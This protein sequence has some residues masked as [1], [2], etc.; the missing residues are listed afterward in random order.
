MTTQL[1]FCLS[2]IAAA[3]ILLASRAALAQDAP[4]T[5]AAPV[6]SNPLAGVF[7]LL[8]SN[9]LPSLAGLIQPEKMGVLTD[10]PCTV[11]ENEADID[12]LSGNEMN[13]LSGN[14]LFSGIT[15]H[16]EIHVDRGERSAAE[17]QAD[18]ANREKKAAKTSKRK[19]D[20]RP[21]Q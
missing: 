21:R 18:K 8:G 7:D 12:L 19:T 9:A 6:Q 1:K 11:R 17:R 2:M 20:R 13:V 4:A 3:C 10:N 15:V 5:A 14:H 16:I